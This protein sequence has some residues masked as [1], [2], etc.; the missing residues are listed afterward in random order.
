MKNY[1]SKL[2]N[3]YTITVYQFFTS[4]GETTAGCSSS[5]NE[6]PLRS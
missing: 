1:L 4:I 5:L 3:N 2:V 6:V